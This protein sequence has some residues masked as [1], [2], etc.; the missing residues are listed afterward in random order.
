MGQG[1]DGRVRIRIGVSAQAGAREALFRRIFLLRLAPFLVQSHD[2]SAVTVASP[3]VVLARPPTC[4][5]S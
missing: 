1:P 5:Y 2:H 4:D 3:G